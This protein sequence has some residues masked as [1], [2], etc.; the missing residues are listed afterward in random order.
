MYLVWM[1]LINKHFT[2]VLLLVNNL[3]FFGFRV[4]LIDMIPQY[5]GALL[6]QKRHSFVWH[7]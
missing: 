2:T 4:N 7:L 1:E 6:S 3:F 5:Q